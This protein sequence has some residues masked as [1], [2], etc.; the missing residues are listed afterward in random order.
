MHH[1][2][3]GTYIQ[4]L[5][6]RIVEA[7][8]QYGFTLIGVPEHLAAAAWAHRRHV[9]LR[10]CNAPIYSV[11]E[12]LALPIAIPRETTLYWSPH[13]NIPIAHR[14]RMVVTIHDLAHLALPHIFRG[15]HR[16][17]YARAMYG[18]VRRR[19]D[20]ILCDSEFTTREYTRLVGIGRACPKTVHLGVDERWFCVARQHRPH[21]RPFFLYIGNVKPNKN[22]GTLVR[23][24]AQ[25]SS[26]VPH[27]LIIVGRREGFITADSDAAHAAASLGARVQFTDFLPTEVLEQFV[28]FA[29]A[30]V[31]P[32][33]YEG[34]GLPPLEAMAA[35][36]PVIVSRAASLPEVCGDAALYFD[37]TDQAE[38]AAC[39]V[40][41]ARSPSLQQDLRIRG[42]RRA[43]QFRWETTAAQTL[44]VLD[45]LVAA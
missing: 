43:Q 4:A 26:A 36:C 30:L 21:P 1:S 29:D 40:Q 33:L 17:Q 7:R 20:A 32:S 39:L 16:R 34:F 11:A 15:W 3:I 23:A 42:R 22:L 14:G 6:P 27:D 24:F 10:A 41:L 37:A 31:M 25:V 2:G 5:V 38:L 28:A 13:Y 9:R 45:A 12:Q 35:S 44:E 19:A 8:P 18:F